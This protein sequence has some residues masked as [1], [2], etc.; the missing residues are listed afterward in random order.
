MLLPNTA[1]AA[2]TKVVLEPLDEGR[3]RLMAPTGGLAIGEV[4]RFEKL[5]DRP[6]RMYQGDTWATRINGF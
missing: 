1:D 6:M 4:V 5:P 2:E 3:F